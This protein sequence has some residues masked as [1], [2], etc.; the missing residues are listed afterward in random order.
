MIV[1]AQE[2]ES[3]QRQ[4]LASSGKI[5]FLFFRHKEI[6][7]QGPNTTETNNTPIR[8]NGQKSNRNKENFE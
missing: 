2:I 7:N 5:L 8:T 4:F 6:I 1:V 3:N